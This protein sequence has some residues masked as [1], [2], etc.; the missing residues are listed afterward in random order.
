MQLHD[1]ADLRR[2]RPYPAVSLLAPLDA[3]RPGNA[4]DPIRLRDLLDRARTRLRDELGPRGSAE[5]V[6]RL[7]RAV[8]S[9]DLDHPSEGVAIFVAPGETH[10]L[11]TSFPVPERLEVAA[12]FATRDLVRG[13]TRTLP[14]RVLALGE[15]PTRCFE[16]TG[17][18]LEEV[19][20]HGFPLFA[21]GARGEPI[22]SGGYAP[23]TRPAV[24]RREQFFRRVDA[25][26]ERVARDDP[27][28]LVLA[29]PERDLA[30]F[31]AVTRHRDQVIGTVPGNYETASPRALA[32]RIAPVL[33][34]HLA[35]RRAQ[36][37]AEL[38]EAVGTG[39]GVVG[40]VPAW[41]A[42]RAGRARVL[43]VEDGYLY[44]AR[45]ADGALEQAHDPGGPGV[46]D[47]VDELIE[48]VL[49]TGGDVVVFDPGELGEHGPVAL[50]LRY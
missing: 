13:L 29:G 9:V 47:A 35:A 25:A 4:A 43:L 40:M 44:P 18:R 37:H 36:L 32:E 8:G 6:D 11:P 2:P 23:H 38:A 21:E 10:V 41:D 39:R 15:K 33:D 7:E 34:A 3:H 17:T 46:V 19:V 42:T 50:L 26:L 31:D 28:P 24:A 27:R 12:T 20:A 5:I 30:A 1:L 16:G 49:D 45:I 48:A 22:P 14:V